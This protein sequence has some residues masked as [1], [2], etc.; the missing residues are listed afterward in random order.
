[1]TVVLTDLDASGIATLTINRPEALNA[2]NAEV[3]DAVAAAARALFGKAKAIIVTGAGKAFVA[4]ADIAQMQSLG[5]VEAEA[6]ARR[7]HEFGKALAEF[8]G[9]VIA[10]INGYALG[11]G[12]ELAMACDMLVASEKAVVGQPE[13]KLGVVPG[14]GGSQRLPRRTGPGIAKWLLMTGETVKADEALRLGIVDKIV[15][16]DALLAECR[17]IAEACLAN[18]PLAVAS[19]K[20]LVDRGLDLPLPQALDL[21]AK[22]FGDSFATHDQ[23]EGMKAF[24]EKRKAAFSGR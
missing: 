19:V 8:P 23:K 5:K 2:L 14:F 10:A 7:G 3:L 17:K 12:L 6:F 22:A 18:G 4:G 16:H 1:M 11:G 9:P 24:L 20:R 13:A 21:E 15:P